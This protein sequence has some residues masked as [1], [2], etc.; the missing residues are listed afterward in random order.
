M[1]NT[2]KILILGGGTA[3][4]MAANLMAKKWQGQPIT[5]SLLESE[6]IGIIG[7]GEGSTPSLKD[8]FSYIDVPEQE[9]MPACNATYKNGITFKNWSS[10]A[11][12]S[13]YCHPFPSQLDD[14]TADAFIYNAFVRRKGIDVEAH[15]DQFLFAS[16]LCKHGLAPQ[17]AYHFPFNVS[18]GYHFDSHLLGKFLKNKAKERGVIHLEGTVATVEQHPNGDIARLV[19]AEG[20]AVDADFFVDCSGFKAVLIQQC[21]KEPF[22]S[23]GDNL[24][25]DTAV[26]MPTPA[27]DTVNSQ[28][29]ATALKAGW[30]WDIPLT[31]R[32]G[33]GYVFSSAFCSH[34]QAE[35]ELRS[36]LG[37]L[38]SAESVRFLKMNVG[39]VQRHW[40]KNCLAVGLSQG[41]IEPL[42]ATALHLVQETLLA[43]I[44]AYSAANF[45]DKN[46]DKFNQLI[47]HR[48]ESVRDYIVC[49]YKVNSRTDTDY[50]KANSSNN[51][52]SESLRSILQCWVAGAD[53]QQEIERQQ[54]GRY[55]PSISWH[56]LLAGYGIFPDQSQLKP[57][58]AAA[59]K[60]NMTTIRDFVERCALNYQSHQQILQQLHRA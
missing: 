52:I 33:N 30:A 19:T 9:W 20:K 15:P 55:F 13:S 41:F 45:T 21:L 7:V 58:N 3:G 34:D 39:R 12:F 60:Y 18:Y 29:I 6:D 51:N 25:N 40:A 36:K 10:K 38:N 43:F 48:F 59:L 50:W 42:E 46:Q 57:G 47:N 32:T 28:T 2:K 23:F 31:N 24:F 56:C 1:Q 22:I 49:H 27:T 8:F 35:T 4:W 37:L 14:Y 44:E 26:V 5:I 17:A 16:H 53:L 11:G 54:I